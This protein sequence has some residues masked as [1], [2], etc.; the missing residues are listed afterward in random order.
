MN[1]K[2]LISLFSSAALAF[3]SVLSSPAAAADNTVSTTTRPVTSHLE[4]HNVPYDLEPKDGTAAESKPHLIVENKIFDD[5]DDARGQVVRVTL[6]L[7]GKNLDNKYSFTGFFVQWD[8]RL[9]TV[10]IKKGRYVDVG[11]ALVELDC[12]PTN[13]GKNCIHLSSAGTEDY[14]IAGD[15]W[16]IDFRLP[17]NVRD[18]DVFPIDVYYDIE[19]KN[20]ECRFTNARFDDKGK[21][22]Q[23]YF[24]T[25]GIYSNQN[26]STDPY[27]VK[28]Y[29]TFADGYI[30]IDSSTAVTTTKTTATTTTKKTTTATTT[31]KK[32]TTTTSTTKSST[33]KTSTTTTKSTATT[34]TKKSTSTSSTTTT[35][36]KP[37]LIG[38]ANCDNDVSVADSVLIMQSISNPSKYSV[39]GSDKNRITE[40]G[41][42]NADCCNVGDGVTNLDALAIQKYKLSL[43]P[44]L[45]EKN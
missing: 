36:V 25:Q 31:T 7:E 21:L 41:K 8:D 43:I 12:I 17:D 24:F 39:K 1:C 37:T 4:V 13:N 45:P 3:G 18:G 23:A 9:E 35:A 11:T 2:R 16:Y 34:T 6:R 27:L 26:L 44:S 32:S 33:T 29:A 42:L 15:M 28:A 30:A 20:M 19:Q 5:P 14:G 10:P 22:M 38:D 40:K